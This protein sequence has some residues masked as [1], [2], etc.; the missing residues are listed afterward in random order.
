MGGSVS[1]PD[2]VE[3]ISQIAAIFTG[4]SSSRHIHGHITPGCFSHRCL[5]VLVGLLYFRTWKHAGRDIQKIQGT[6]F[7]WSQV[8]DERW[9]QA[10]IWKTPWEEQ[11]LLKCLFSL[12]ESHPLKTCLF[13]F[14]FFCCDK[15]YP[16]KS[17]EKRV[18]FRLH[19]QVRAGTWGRHPKK[20]CCL[21]AFPLTCSASFLVHLST[22]P[23]TML[24]QLAGPSHISHLSQ[25]WS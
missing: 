25:A 12:I 24:P 5:S 14:A 19:F 13:Q 10:Q 22:C 21:L 4:Y 15:Q 2:R 20:K 11:G 9:A 18:Y 7:C 8:F 23:E 6:S 17:G 3:P 16:P 1:C